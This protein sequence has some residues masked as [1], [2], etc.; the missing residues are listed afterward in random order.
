M[1]REGPY[2]L[3]GSTAIEPLVNRWSAWSDLISPVP[4]SLHMLNYQIKVLNSYLD[5]PEMHVETSH[6]P[7][8]FGGPFVNVPAE[9]AHQIK[10]MLDE[11]QTKQRDNIDLATAITE[12][13][14][15]I[16]KEGQ[17]QSL[18]PFYEKTPEILRGYVELLYDYHSNPIMRCLES[19]LYESP[20]YKKQLQS[21][22]IFQQR[23]DSSRPFFMSTPR[24]AEKDK[25]DWVVPFENPEVD[26]LFKLESAPQELGFIR[27]LLGLTPADDERL[28]PLLT[29][30][31]P[32]KAERWNGPEARVRYFG[33]A[34]VLVEWKGVAVLTDPWVS[35]DPKG[36]VV[37]R[38]SYKDLPEKIDYALITHAHHDHY[39]LE[40]L[41]RLRHKI[42][43]L[44]V[45]RTFGMFYADTSLRLMSKKMGFKNVVEIEA[46]DS[47]ELDDGEITAVPFLGEHADLAHGKVGYVVR[48]GKEQVLFAADSNC[49]EK[50]VYENV[51]RVVGPIRTVFLGME[52]VG[53][54]LSWMYGT[55]LPTPLQRSHNQSRR[56]KGC[57]SKAAMTLLDAVGAKR[58]YIYAMGREP[59]LQYSLGLGMSETSVQVKESDS[60]IMQAR[61]KG[62]IDAQRPFIKYELYL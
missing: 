43:C 20:F 53:A 10:E 4:Y 15:Y 61:E 23:S 58:V 28:L 1:I 3:A 13:S 39:V 9:R 46:L 30:H 51:R 50:R 27:E 22:R 12:F 5:D 16:H 44:V 29:Q 8:L 34:C 21:L 59:W 33:H 37:E 26:E 35:V 7:K 31:S 32:A 24:L 49:L 2:H 47:I 45:P 42:E 18:E 40:S 62:F 38:L 36:D 54:P 57:D 11:M 55:F 17:G 52:C 14:N 60:V 25:I 56:T 19:L 41:L 48:T 6:D